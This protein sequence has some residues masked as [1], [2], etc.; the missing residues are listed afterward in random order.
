MAIPS[1]DDLNRAM[2]TVLGYK[3]PGFYGPNKSHGMHQDYDLFETREAAHAAF[4]KYWDK[5]DGGVDDLDLCYWK[6]DWGP[7]FVADYASEKDTHT[8]IKHAIDTAQAWRDFSHEMR[9]V[10]IGLPDWENSR[11]F[12]VTFAPPRLVVIAALRALGKWEPGWDEEG[13]EA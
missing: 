6:D 3:N 11:T 1:D 5:Y 4:V 2:A 9:N 10:C 13:E 7:I 8:E 12:T